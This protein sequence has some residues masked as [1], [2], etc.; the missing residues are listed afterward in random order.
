MSIFFFEKS[1]VFLKFLRASSQI[2][3]C[4]VCKI[5]YKTYSVLRKYLK[6]SKF[7]MLRI[8]SVKKKLIFKKK[9]EPA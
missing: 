2:T 3:A 8:N 6:F 9:E 5:P 7:F 4:D 1:Q